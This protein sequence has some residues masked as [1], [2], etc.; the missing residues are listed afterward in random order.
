[1][2]TVVPE[3]YSFIYQCYATNSILN[4][5]ESYKI[6]SKEGVHQGDPLCPFL[7]SLESMPLINS[8]TSELKVFYLDNGT[9][10]G[11]VESVLHDYK[12]IQ[13]TGKNLGLEV[14]STKCE[15]YCIRPESIDTSNIYEKFCSASP[16]QINLILLQDKDLTL[17]G[18]P[19]LQDAIESTLTAKLKSLDLMIERLIEID[20][21]EALFLLRHC[22]SI[23]KLTYLLRNAPCF[24]NTS[25]V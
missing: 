11:S 22:F 14:N 19:I 12:M 18:A 24:L 25:R 9:L 13:N 3:I 10:G 15:L 7:F 8:C 4:F 2:R 1:M 5:G 23:P 20:A 6:E 21:H 16:N 17:L